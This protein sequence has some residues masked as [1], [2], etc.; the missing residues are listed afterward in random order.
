[1]KSARLENY[2]QQL[3]EMGKRLSGDINEL[4]GEIATAGVI[5]GEHTSHARDSIETDIVLEQNES[6]LQQQVR[7][8]LQRIEAGTFGQCVDCG[9]RILKPRLDA[10]PYTPICID[11]ECLRE[12]S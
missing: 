3:L 9:G 8:A 6:A 1:M 12:S 11:C 4:V 7:S 10:L 5:V 2:K